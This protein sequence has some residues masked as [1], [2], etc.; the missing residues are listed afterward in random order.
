MMRSPSILITSA[1]RR[2]ELVSYFQE[3]LIRLN[4]IDFKVIATDTYPDLSAACLKCSQAYAVPPSTSDS[5]IESLL[6]ICQANNVRILIPTHD[7]ELPIL[8]L[9]RQSFMQIG[10]AI[11]IPDHP[12]VQALCDK[13]QTASFFRNINVPTPQIYSPSDLTFPLFLKPINGSSSIGAR[14][15]SDSS[16]LSV[17][18]TLDPANVFQE[19]IPDSFN[20]YSI[21]LLYSN[22]GHLISA[23]PR[24]R[25]ATRGG[26]ISKGRVVRDS[27]YDYVQDK[28]RHIYS[29]RGVMTLQLFW[30][31]DSN[32]IFAIEINPR[33]GGGYPMSHLSGADYPLLLLREYLLG[34]TLSFTDSWAAG[35]LF[36]R[37]DTTVEANNI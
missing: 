2:V 17:S 15:V 26:E 28:M 20:E 37:Y 5:Y 9:A 10:T 33:F 21:D 12:L 31:P 32:E 8:S 13:K 30:N 11:P 16:A 7:A 27:V 22:N 19:L 35:G 23:V 29:A 25:L 34:E 4:L 14:K 1:G 24:R 3:A 18:E 36:L 6:E